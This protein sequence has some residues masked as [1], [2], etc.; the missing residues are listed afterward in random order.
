M[1]NLFVAYSLTAWQGKPYEMDLG[2]TLTYT[3]EP[4]KAKYGALDDEMC[5]ALQS[6]PALFVNEKQHNSPGRIGWITKIRHRNKEA[7]IEYEIDRNLPS[8]PMEKLLGLQWELDFTDWEMNTTHWALKDVDLFPAL[9][10]A[11]LLTADMIAAQPTA[12]KIRAIN[13]AQT[14][15]EIEARPTV[16]RT[17]KQPRDPNLVSVMMPF[18]P[19]F[20]NV[21]AAIQKAV[22]A[23]GLTCERADNI[24]QENEVIQDIFSLIYRSRIVVCDFTQQNPNVFYEAGIAHTLG[25]SVIPISQNDADVPFDLKHHRYLKYLNNGE[26]LEDLVKHLTFRLKTLSGGV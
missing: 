18:S 5:Q 15:S 22:Q 19:T 26:G 23:A 4:L 2:R 6:F 7:R 1:Y 3:A 14:A 10:E 8:M 21:Y 20:S 24:W 16:F 13:T 17:P 12:N 11:G 25:R 9:I